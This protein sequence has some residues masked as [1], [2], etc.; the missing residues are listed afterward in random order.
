MKKIT[1]IILISVFLVFAIL[2]FGLYKTIS[3][4]SV[5]VEKCSAL[6]ESSADDCWHSLAHQ[7]LNRTYCYNINDNI[8]KEHCL[9]HIPEVNKDNK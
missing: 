9:E 4:Y 7:T 3:G 8:T 1:L 2:F 6:S 5:S